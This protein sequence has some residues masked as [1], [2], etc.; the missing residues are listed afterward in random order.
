MNNIG[1]EGARALAEYLKQNTKLTELNLSSMLE[2][3][4][5]LFIIAR[6]DISRPMHVYSYLANMIGDMGYRALAESLKQNTTLTELNLSC[7][8]ELNKLLLVAAW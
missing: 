4:D 8:L 5:L 6:W 1:D 7:T 3:H 2:L